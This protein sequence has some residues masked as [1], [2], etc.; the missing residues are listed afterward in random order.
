ME[1]ICSRGSKVFPFKIDPFKK[2]DKNIFD[3]DA[4]LESVPISLIPMDI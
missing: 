4:F 2:K 3:S 1:R